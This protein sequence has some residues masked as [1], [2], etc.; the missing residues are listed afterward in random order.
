[1]FSF[2][3][4]NP[5]AKMPSI[6]T[7]DGR[8]AWAFAAICGGCMTFTLFAAAGVWLVKDNA[9]YAFMLAL[10][11]HGQVLVGMS[12]LG[13]VLGRRA[14]ISVTKDSLT[15]EDSKTKTTHEEIGT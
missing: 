5:L 3:F 9:H 2:R 8:R 1:M 7:H 10:A 6:A 12:A 14:N 4:P 15:I 13:W 11:A